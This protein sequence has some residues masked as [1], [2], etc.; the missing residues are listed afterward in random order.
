MLKPFAGAFV[1]EAS[2]TS[3]VRRVIAECKGTCATARVRKE[4]LQ[5]NTRA[6]TQ[7]P[8]HSKNDDSVERVLMKSIRGA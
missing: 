8:P 4:S 1:S 6:P 5:A 2:E 3:Q 7:E